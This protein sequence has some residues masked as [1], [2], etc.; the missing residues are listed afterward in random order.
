MNLHY[1]AAQLLVYAVDSR[2]DDV[3][4]RLSRIIEHLVDN[5]QHVFSLILEAI[6][7]GIGGVRLEKLVDLSRF[8]SV[9]FHGL[10]PSPILVP[11]LVVVLGD[12]QDS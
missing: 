7:H 4:E 9:L 5:Q 11:G 10:L 1:V 12:L 8:R 2:C 6:I 3:V